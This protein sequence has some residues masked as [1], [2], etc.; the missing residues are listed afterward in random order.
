MAETDPDLSDFGFRTVHALNF[1]RDRPPP[2][3][4]KGYD[5]VDSGYPLSY[6]IG[7][8]YQVSPLVNLRFDYAYETPTDYLV[9]YNGSWES[10]LMTNYDKRRSEDPLS[11]HSFFLGLRYLHR[12]KTTLFPL[13]TGFFYSTNMDDEPLD[14]NVSLG[15]SIGGGINRED[16][17]LGF[18]WRFRIWDNPEDQFL[19]ELEMEEL[20][21][22]V[23][24]Q[25]LFTLLF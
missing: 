15:F 14:S 2:G 25:F 18:A 13:H 12:Q 16:F 19:K 17:R 22:R 4:V 1:L 23:S 10:S 20:E 7:L 21:T 9:E 5:G 11:I 24:N 6:G 8:N 3:Y